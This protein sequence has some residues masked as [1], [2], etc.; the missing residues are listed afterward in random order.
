MGKPFFL[1]V[2][3]YLAHLGKAV[4]DHS[5]L[6]FHPP[7]HPANQQ[8]VL[9]RGG[10]RGYGSGVS[11]IW[12]RMGRMRTMR[13]PLTARCAAPGHA[14]HVFQVH[15]DGRNNAEYMDKEPGSA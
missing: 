12:R 4:K 9:G 6:S 8:P 14:L 15:S 2:S 13:A 5:A 1:L 3:F 11:W 10:L 7:F